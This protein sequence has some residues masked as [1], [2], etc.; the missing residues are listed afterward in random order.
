MRRTDED[1]IGLGQHPLERHEVWVDGDSTRLEQVVNN[2]VTNALKYSPEDTPVRVESRGEPHE[3]VVLD[4]SGAEKLLGKG[5]MLFLQPGTSTLMR[6][7]GTYAAD[8]EITRVVT[9]H[10]SVDASSWCMVVL[11]MKPSVMSRS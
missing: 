11:D 9:A 5:D 4:E 6:A 3:V 8:E 7:Q 1:E 2:L 10:M